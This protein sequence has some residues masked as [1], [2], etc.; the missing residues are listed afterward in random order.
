MMAPVALVWR[1]GVARWSVTEV[2]RHDLLVAAA[3]GEFGERAEWEIARAGDEWVGDA[4]GGD[5]YR[6]AGVVERV[7]EGPVG[8]IGD[9]RVVAVCIVGVAVGGVDGAFDVLLF[10]AEL[11]AQLL[12]SLDDA[13]ADAKVAWAAEITRRVADAR[14]NPHDDEDWRTALDEIRRELLSR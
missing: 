8:R 2:V 4:R 6:P 12:A 13:E 3:V 14:Q 5:A 9:G 11:A 10:R 1:V 7:E